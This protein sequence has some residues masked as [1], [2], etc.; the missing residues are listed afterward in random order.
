[1]AAYLV[2]GNPGSG[3][4][5]LAQELRR[6][7]LSAID[8]DCDPGLSYWE[9]EDGARVSLVD[10]P[11]D[12]G[13]EWLQ[14]HRWVWHRARLEELLAQQGGPTFVCGIALN[15]DQVQDL[16]DEIFLLEIDAAT[17]E[18][19]LASHDAQNP[20]GRSEAGREQIRR[21]R[22][23]FQTQMLNLGAIAVDGTVPTVV[24]ADQ[25]LALA[26]DV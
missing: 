23:V 24:V 2:T 11:S 5:G 3:K 16:F 8:P 6:R 17:Q 22:D 21:G 1:V 4:S 25:V 19:R 12:P 26:A 9:A 15:I 10:G 7:G 14:S 18:A 13:S 20:P